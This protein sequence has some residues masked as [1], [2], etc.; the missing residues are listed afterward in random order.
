MYA[1]QTD[2]QLGKRSGGGAISLF[3]RLD[4]ASHPEQAIPLEERESASKGS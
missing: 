3:V 4:T 2:L 1:I